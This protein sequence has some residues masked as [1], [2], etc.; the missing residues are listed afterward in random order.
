MELRAK[1]SI[2]LPINVRY[3]ILSFCDLTFILKPK[4]CLQSHRSL[5]CAIR[6]KSFRISN[7]CNLKMRYRIDSVELGL[8]QSGAGTVQ[9]C[10]SWT[11]QVNY[12]QVNRFDHV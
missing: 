10:G 12:I 5:E 4:F 11:A 3:T 9:L 6:V 2:S 1:L 8:L 7:V